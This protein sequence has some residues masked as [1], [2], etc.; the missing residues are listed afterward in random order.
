MQTLAPTQKLALFG[1]AERMRCSGLS[2]EFIATAVETALVFEGVYDLMN[3]WDT[4]DETSER[5]EIIAD[6]Q[7]MIDECG[8][9]QKVEGVYVRF[10]D[11]ETIA[12]HITAFKDSLRIK[13]EE[14]GGISKLSELTGIPQPSLSRFFGSA[15]MPRRVTLLKIAKALQLSQVEIATEWVH[16]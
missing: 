2:A 14:N 12:Q 8:Q 1:I 6:I 4:E 13:V 10:N 9:T 16:L 11:L 15:S 3:L 5:Q 7:D